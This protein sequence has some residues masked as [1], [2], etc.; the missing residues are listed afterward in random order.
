MTIEERRKICETIKQT[1]DFAIECLLHDI[2][3]DALIHTISIYREDSQLFTDALIAARA[4]AI[5][6]RAEAQKL[7]N[8]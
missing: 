1:T 4:D 8:V 3:P 5:E 6:A 2:Q 7:R